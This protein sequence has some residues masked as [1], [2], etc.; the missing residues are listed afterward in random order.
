[1]VAAVGVVF[2][3]HRDNQNQRGREHPTIPGPIECTNA[4]KRATVMIVPLRRAVL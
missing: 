3:R 2:V 1:V 4:V